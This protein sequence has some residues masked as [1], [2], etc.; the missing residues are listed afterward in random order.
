[1]NQEMFTINNLM[2]VLL[3]CL[4]HAFGFCQSKQA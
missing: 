2:M 1:M 4:Y 3:F